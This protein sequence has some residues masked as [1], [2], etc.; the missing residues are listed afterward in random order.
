MELRAAPWRRATHRGLSLDVGRAVAE[1]PLIVEALVMRPGPTDSLA[2]GYTRVG[3][4]SGFIFDPATALT[5]ELL[6]ATRLGATMWTHFM[7]CGFGLVSRQNVWRH[8][9]CRG[10]VR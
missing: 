1:E 6:S 2:C 7:S 3:L 4:S 8:V 9:Q 10:S 5:A